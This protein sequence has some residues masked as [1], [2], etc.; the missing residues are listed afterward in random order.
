MPFGAAANYRVKARQYGRREEAAVA[1]LVLQTAI[2][3]TFIFAVFATA[4]S[5]VSEAVTRYL[6]LRGEYLLRGIRSLVDGASDFR[7]PW[8]ELMPWRM[9]KSAV[10]RRGRESAASDHAMAPQIMHHPLV[11]SSAKEAKPPDRA[12]DVPLSNQERRKLPSYLS[13][14][15]FARALID[16]VTREHANQRDRDPL[17][18]VRDWANSAA[19][20]HEHLAAAIRPLATAAKDLAALEKSVA[21]WYDDHMARV[22]GWYKRHVK[23]IS[24][25]IGLILVL[26]FNVNALKIADSL[27]SDQALS[28]SV[29]AEATRASSCQG[30]A[31][32]TC[33]ADL[34]SEVG[35]IRGTGLPIGWGDAPECAVRPSCSWLDRHGLASIDR[36]GSA[37]VWT[38]LLVLLGWA[39]MFLALLPGSRFW[40]DLLSR[41]GSLRSTGPKPAP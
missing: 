2:G 27:Y 24:L 19:E 29:V 7:L 35:K 31:P 25:A 10:D 18:A 17:E 34:R 40:F 15:T 32:A 16:I 13:G 23:W 21:R 5:A 28:T 4:V 14:E 22:A 33:L 12:G 11:A 20:G 9:G 6:G 8:S 3:L 36:N 37:D 38:F 26:A 1:S 39:V 30:E 41:L